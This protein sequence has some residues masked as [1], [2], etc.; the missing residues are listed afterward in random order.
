ML[1]YQTNATLRK[2]L[3]ERIV[4][5]VGNP[6]EWPQALRAVA[7][8]LS[9]DLARLDWLVPSL[10][11]RVAAVIDEASKQGRTA[12]QIRVAIGGAL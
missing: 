2:T 8:R 12:D 6:D 5:E 1:D 7:E 10:H 11:G 3:C 4:D 9:L